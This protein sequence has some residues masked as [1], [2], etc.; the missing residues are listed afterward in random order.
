MNLD[1]LKTRLAS[2][3]AKLDQALRLNTIAVRELQLLKTRSSLQWLTRGV[4]FELL[5]GI[6]A[7][8]WLGDFIAGHLHEPRFLVPALLID[9]GAIAYLGACIRQLLVLGR[10]NYNLPVLAVQKEL[11]VLRVLRTST[12]KWTLILSFVLWFPLLLVLLRGLLG[13]DLWLVLGAIGDRHASFFAWIVTNVAFGL[14][15]ASSLIWFSHRYE[16]RPANSPTIQRFMDVLAGRS[17]T[18]AQ[19]SLDSIVAFEA[20]G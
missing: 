9:L 8:V 18:R 6:I 15:V 1:D 12:T 4:V 16:S 17:L 11:G 19:Q 20:E 7:V 13:V 14:A 3:D 10:L 2:H 5:T